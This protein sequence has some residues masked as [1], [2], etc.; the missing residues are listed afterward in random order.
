MLILGRLPVGQDL[1]RACQ[2]VLL[3]WPGSELRA[4]F[5]ATRL[6]L[7][8]AHHRRGALRCLDRRP[9]QPAVPDRDAWRRYT[10]TGLAS[11]PHQ[12]RLQKRTEAAA[13]TVEVR[14]I[15]LGVGASSCHRSA[16]PSRR[17][18]FI[19][20]SMTVGACVLDDGAEDWGSRLR[21]AI[22]SRTRHVSPTRSAQHRAIA[23]SGLGVSRSQVPLRRPR[24]L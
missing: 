9:A 21:T 15:E 16:L 19:G 23:V 17:L 2:R 11:R 20:D 13:G 22:V 10:L 3:S 4:Q 12:L 6:T 1:A 14:A 7:R 8:S 18:E 24:P 5:H